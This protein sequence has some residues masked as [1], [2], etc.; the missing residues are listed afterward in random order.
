MNNER[1]QT[2]DPNPN[3][4]NPGSPVSEGLTKPPRTPDTVC[5]DSAT[6]GG[7]EG[8]GGGVKSDRSI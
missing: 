5:A 7:S 2:S 8:C 1:T 4:I 3:T 6:D